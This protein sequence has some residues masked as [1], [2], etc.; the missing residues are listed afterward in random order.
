MKTRTALNRLDVAPDFP[1]LCVVVAEVL[2]K[3]FFSFST[4]PT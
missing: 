2:S 1:W 3:A 4:T